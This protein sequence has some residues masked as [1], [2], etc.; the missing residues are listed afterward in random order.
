M[1]GPWALPA[2]GRGGRW[3]ISLYEIKG[4]RIFGGP[5]IFY[6]WVDTQG[7][8]HPRALKNFSCSPK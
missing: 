3:Y 7:K 4:K 6:V 2:D 5:L 8:N 1:I